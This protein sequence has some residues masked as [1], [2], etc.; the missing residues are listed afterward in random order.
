MTNPISNAAATDGLRPLG[1]YQSLSRSTE[2]RHVSV[3]TAQNSDRRERM[4]P[5]LS[6][7]EE[8]SFIDATKDIAA[9]LFSAFRNE[10]RE[11]LSQIGIRGEKAADIVREVGKSFVEAV[12]NGSGFSFGLM[13]AAYK[14]T[15]TQSADSVSHALEFSAKSLVIEYNHATGELT[16]DTSELELDAVKTVRGDNLPAEVASLFDFTDGE[17]VPTLAGLFDR[18]QQYLAQ[19]GF[20][21]EEGADGET[22]PLALPSADEAA[23]DTILANEEPS[24]EAGDDAAEAAV[25]PSPDRAAL[26]R[27]ALDAVKIRAVEEYTNERQET[28]TRTTFDLV[29]RVYLDATK[30]DTPNALSFQ[31]SSAE[32]V[33]VTA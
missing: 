11:A 21:G 25:A 16:A 19:Y 33:N 14:E 4:T 20:L 17:G 24:G 10:L 27:A 8:K 29:V 23:Y 15:I 5:T 9:N 1:A 30:N 31:S 2:Q 32:T 7:G 22:L 13:A 12:R 26:D 18:V 6:A 3:D 28:I